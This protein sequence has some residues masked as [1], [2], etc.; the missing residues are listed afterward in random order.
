M[1][2]Q[3]LLVECDHCETVIPVVVRETGKPAPIGTGGGCPCG[4]HAFTVDDDPISLSN[5]D[6]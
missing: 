4:S 3:T 6:S 1:S 5:R 2:D